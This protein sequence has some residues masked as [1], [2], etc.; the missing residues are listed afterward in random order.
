MKS[1]ILGKMRYA[2][3]GMAA[4]TMAGVLCAQA[5]AAVVSGVSVTKG[6]GWVRLNIHAPGGSFRVHELPVG[7]SAYRSIAID[8]PN[9]S[10]VGGWE[11]KQRL[12]VNEGLVAQVRVK[13]MGG[14]VR[15]LV[16]VV[17]FPKYQSGFSNGNFVLG[18]DPYHMRSGN[19]IAP[20]IR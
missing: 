15:V 6:K 8:V 16:D 19:P 4:L 17:S 11:P 5:N 14:Y 13:Q 2:G 9:S 10:I 18:M 3:L 1:W 12:P 7:T 20:Q